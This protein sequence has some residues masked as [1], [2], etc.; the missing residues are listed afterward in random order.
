MKTRP[1]IF[2]IFIN[3]FIN[4]PS[5]LQVGIDALVALRDEENMI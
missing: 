4:I 2:F 1:H 3:K 5:R